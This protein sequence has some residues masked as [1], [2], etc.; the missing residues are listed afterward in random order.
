MVQFWVLILVYLHRVEHRFLVV[1]EAMPFLMVVAG[2]SFAFGWKMISD[3]I[4]KVQSSVRKNL[5]YVIGLASPVA[6]LIS[7][8][9]ASQVW[10]LVG[11]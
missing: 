3:E 5:Y 7:W 8:A 2:V 9:A 6:A 10:H 1:E 4:A 11:M